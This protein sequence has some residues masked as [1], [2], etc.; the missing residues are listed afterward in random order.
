MMRLNEDFLE[1]GCAIQVDYKFKNGL[2]QKHKFA[3]PDGL[4][5]NFELLYQFCN[6]TLEEQEEALNDYEMK[7]LREEELPNNEALP[8]SD[9]EE[10]DFENEEANPEEVELPEEKF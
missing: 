7:C 4:D 9:G 6:M 2:M 1:S 3:I 8:D 5:R 10:E